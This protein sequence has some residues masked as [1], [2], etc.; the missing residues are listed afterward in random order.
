M[1][2]SDVFALSSRWEGLVNVVM[3]ALGLG[4]PVVSTDCPSGPREILADG[5]FGTLVPM[6]DPEAL[7]DAL[8]RTL[9]GEGPTFEREDA[10][11]PFRAETAARAY[12]DFFGLASP[13]QGMPR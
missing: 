11:R 4:V 7:A 6:Q 2:R 9:R 5:R 12:L 1:A 10:V 3:E 13:G 8:D